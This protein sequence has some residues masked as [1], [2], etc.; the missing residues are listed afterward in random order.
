MPNSPSGSTSAIS[1]WSS[2]ETLTTASGMV[3]PVTEIVLVLTS[4]PSTGCIISRNKAPDVA[5]EVG[6]GVG[7]GVVGVAVDVG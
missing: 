7:V 3:F 1:S 4:A 6:L 2:T 5:V